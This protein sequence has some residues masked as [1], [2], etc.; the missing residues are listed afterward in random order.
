MKNNQKGGDHHASHRQAMNTG[1][2][3]PHKVP[4]ATVNPEYVPPV[5][6]FS[7]FASKQAPAVDSAKLEELEQQVKAMKSSISA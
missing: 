2:S 4:A 5:S 1:K 6:A 3:A 7:V